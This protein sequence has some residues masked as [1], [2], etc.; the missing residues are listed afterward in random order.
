MW[1][2]C[3]TP[4]LYYKSMHRSLGKPTSSTRKVGINDSSGLAHIAGV[5]SYSKSQPESEDI[6]RYTMT[7]SNIWS[8]HA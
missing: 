3:E 4:F 1:H 7:H 8:S 6:A 2:E 5:A